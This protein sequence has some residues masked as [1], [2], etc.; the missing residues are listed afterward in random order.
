MLSTRSALLLGN[1]SLL[2]VQALIVSAITALLS[3]LLGLIIS[4]AGNPQPSP[5]ISPSLRKRRPPFHK[6]PPKLDRPQSGLREYVISQFVF[7]VTDATHRF[8]MILSTS[9]ASASIS[10][11]ILGSFMCSLIL[12][13]RRF[14]FNPGLCPSHHLL[15]DPLAYPRPKR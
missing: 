14:R 15:S 9:M 11:L 2:Q 10:G 6:L 8:S 4:S 3:F 7:L 13:C 5:S 12:L 1:L